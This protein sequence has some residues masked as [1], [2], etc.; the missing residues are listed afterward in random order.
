MAL[1]L[2]S[3]DQVDRAFDISFDLLARSQRRP[4]FGESEPLELEDALEEFVA[5]NTRMLRRI[6]A[7]SLLSKWDAMLAQVI[8]Q[9][10][11]IPGP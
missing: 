9:T 6:G 5:N 3:V 7:G 1:E 10:K 8:E 11:Q 2:G 4:V